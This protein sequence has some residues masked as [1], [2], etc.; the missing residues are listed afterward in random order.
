M[1][2]VVVFDIDGVLADF[3]WGFTALGKQMFGAPVTKTL[4]HAT[5]DGFEGLDHTMQNAMWQYIKASPNFWRLLEPC[6]PE[7]VF[8]NISMLAQAYPVYFVTNRPGDTAKQQTEGW[9]KD[10]GIYTPTVIVSAA[11]GYTAEAVGAT[12]FIDDK[13]GNA[14]FAKYHCPTMCTYLLDRLYNRFDQTVIGTK[15]KRIESV[16]KFLEEVVGE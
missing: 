1:K 2:R 14:V 6:I 15:V 5:W 3:T 9:L 12:H 7:Y 16:E 13:A 11:K 8:G 10:H 4:T